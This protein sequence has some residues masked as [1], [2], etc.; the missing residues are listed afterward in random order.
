MKLNY[1]GFLL[2]ALLA[3]CARF[4]PKPVSPAQ[5]AAGLEA[6]RLDD[7]AFQEFLA[8]NLPAGSVER[9][10]RT[11]SFEMLNLAALYYHPSLEVARAEWQVALGGQITAAQR[12]N[13]TLTATPGYD[14]N[15]VGQLSPWL[16]L[17]FIDWP[18]ETMG[19]RGYRKAQ[20]EALSHS[21]RLNISVTAWQ[22]RAN[23]RACLTDYSAARRREELLAK[24]LALQEKIATALD[25][26]FQA[27]AIARSELGLVRIALEKLRLDLNDTR[28]QQADARVRVADAVGIPVKALD[29]LEFTDD[30]QTTGA[31]GQEPVSASI[32][33]RALQ[34]RAD[35]LAALAEYAASQSALQL[36]I[37]RQ[38]PDLHLG[39][40]YQFDHGEHTFSLQLTAELPLLNQNQGPI[41][42]AKARRAAAAARFLAVQARVIT[43]IDRALAGYRVA[44]DNLAAIESLAAAQQR[45]AAAVQALAREGEAAP[46]DLLNTQLELGA[47]ELTLLDARVK[48][49]R[50]VAALED[51]LQQPLELMKPALFEQSP[52]AQAAV[53]N[54]SNKKQ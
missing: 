15:P 44:R 46:V 26:Q 6:R 54:N 11:W 20:A 23:L 45:Q 17:T 48:I 24:Q 1:S 47:G 31:G 2:L 43:E 42:E 22:V 27:G 38:Y 51:A 19:K 39:P 40:G 10:A 30:L 28:Q 35:V 5:T 33:D 49:L 53:Q 7:P 52:G 9:G 16:P 34:S 8:R 21:A 32:R 36:E 29:G 37:A 4:E 13:P 3:G 12:P 14:F 18:I 25:Q 50:S 41:A